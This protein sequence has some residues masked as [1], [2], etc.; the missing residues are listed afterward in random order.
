MA[1]A[2]IFF[3][4]ALIITAMSPLL[5]IFLILYVWFLFFYSIFG[6]KPGY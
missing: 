1:D 5:V 3:I 6:K 2:I 4:L